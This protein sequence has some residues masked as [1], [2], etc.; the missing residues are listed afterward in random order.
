[1]EQTNGMA[2]QWKH[3]HVAES[4]FEDPKRSEDK[5]L[6]LAVLDFCQRSADVMLSIE[7][8]ELVALRTTR[9]LA[10]FR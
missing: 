3:C 1:M 2:C 9:T 10:I 4:L 7:I 6:E 8:V 5:H